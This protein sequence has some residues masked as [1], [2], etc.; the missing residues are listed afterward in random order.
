MTMRFFSLLILFLLSLQVFGKG[1][2]PSLIDTCNC[3]QLED[4]TEDIHAVISK[5]YQDENPSDVPVEFDQLT[6]VMDLQTRLEDNL[7]CGE[8]YGELSE[9]EEG[10]TKSINESSLITPFQNAVQYSGNVSLQE[11]RPRFMRIASEND[12][13]LFFRTMINGEEKYILMFV[14]RDGQTK[15]EILN[16]PPT[17]FTPVEGS[18]VAVAL[19]EQRERQLSV[20]TS[21]A[22]PFSDETT[23][24]SPIQEQLERASELSFPISPEIRQGNFAETIFEGGFRTTTTEREVGVERAYETDNGNTLQFGYLITAD[25]LSV[26]RPVPGDDDFDDYMAALRLRDD[27][28]DIRYLE[29]LQRNQMSR[30]PIQNEDRLGGITTRANLQYSHRFGDASPATDSEGIGRRLTFSADLTRRFDTDAELTAEERALA[31]DYR[32][33][34]LGTSLR[35]T[36]TGEDSPADFELTHGNTYGDNIM[37]DMEI[38][39]PLRIVQPRLSFSQIPSLEVE[40]SKLPRGPKG[41]SPGQGGAS[42]ER[43]EEQMYY[44]VSASGTIGEGVEYLSLRTSRQ[45]SE[46]RG[47][48]D[49]RYN[50]PEERLTFDTARG[51]LDGSR[52]NR[53]EGTIGTEGANSL[54]FGTFRE[55]VDPTFPIGVD[56]DITHTTRLHLTDSEYRPSEISYDRVV[57][58]QQDS[59]DGLHTIQRRNQQ[60]FTASDD[61]VVLR[62]STTRQETFSRDTSIR[63]T[64]Y[65][66]NNDNTA[67]QDMGVQE[68]ASLSTHTAVQLAFND[69][70]TEGTLVHQ[71]E[72]SDV[73]GINGYGFGL[74]A[75]H[76]DEG[77][78]IE[79]SMNYYQ[80]SPSGNE[81]RGCSASIRRELGE[82]TGRAPSQFT[83]LSRVEN[84]TTC[85]IRVISRDDGELIGEFEL[86]R[87]TGNTELY[88]MADTEG[89]VDLGTLTTFEF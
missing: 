49:L 65:E 66:I 31:L 64:P 84:S 27:G 37:A 62:F 60:G 45:D 5:I 50:I 47:Y 71:I 58:T 8:T 48:A 22:F 32:N 41:A 87:R 54:T 2:E 4:F 39:N 1:G 15:V 16:A 59:P 20:P 40:S 73:T 78:A 29:Q 9:F 83:S 6:L 36:D 56:G 3:P 74:Y 88:I 25:G 19:Q 53:V 30:N 89:D 57:K 43:P 24:T 76:G 70:A 26:R 44:T 23:F 86:R 63:E 77:D 10:I 34:D 18:P 7:S 14:D 81:S 17:P 28:S 42:H 68:Y 75:F 35:L 52:I 12:R 46:T 85:G 21:I 13:T 55:E 51:D 72:E 61:R 67:I 33:G 82:N 80:V 69:D 79:A 38:R 11:F